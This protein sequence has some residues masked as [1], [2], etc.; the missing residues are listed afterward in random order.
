M[1]FTVGHAVMLTGRGRQLLSRGREAG[2]GIAG[3]GGGL[4]AWRVGYEQPVLVMFHG[5]TGEGPAE[6]MMARA[7]VAAARSTARAA[8][9]AGFEAVIV[10]TDEPGAFEPL[11]AGV[12]LDVD[13]PGEPFVYR[14]RLGRL[15]ERYGLERPAV[16]GS[17]SVPLLGPDEFALVVEQLQARDAR[18]V[19]NN[20]YSADL[21]GWTPGSAF[22]RLGAVPRDNLLPRLLRDEAG[23]A[24]VMLPRTTATQF[25]L[26]TPTDLAVL[27]LVRGVDPGL[28]MAAGEVA[29]LTERLRGVMPLLCDR[30]AEL[31]VAGRVGSQAW[32]YLERETACRVRMFSEERGLATAPEG[33]RPRSLLGFL[34]E[35]VGPERFFQ[36]LAELG[37]AAVID[38]RVI[39][40]HLGIAPTREDRFQSDLGAWE[41]VREPELRR[42]TKAAMEAPLPVILGGHSLVSGGLMA[43]NDAAWEGR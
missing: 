3:K 35:E 21:T 11:P 31:V 18:F 7:R 28:A 33:H 34:L 13:P 2:G 8:L 16:M 29:G 26:D 20:F 30:S 23:L 9:A 38:T 36:R 27:G 14:E 17:G 4:Y 25:D 42:F 24:P 41:E 40:A 6:R 10:A 22:A 37:D 5:G 32:Q 1:T 12:L 43:L 39:E 19:T 15:I